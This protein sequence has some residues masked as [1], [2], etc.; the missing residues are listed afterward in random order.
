MI[1]NDFVAVLARALR[2]RTIVVLVSV[3]T[4]LPLVGCQILGP[5]AL[6]TGRGAY[7]DVIART[8]S[9]QTLGLIVRLRYSDPF[10]LL[11]VSGVTAGLR[12]STQAK[13]EAGFG[14]PGS[15]AGA[16]V[17]FSAGVSYEDNPLISYTPV[18]A[19]GFLREWLAPVTLETLALAMQGAARQD[20]LML[21]LA[22]VEGMNGLHSG[23]GAAVEE[24]TAFHRAV[25]LLAQFRDLGMALWVQESGATGRY[26]LILSRYSPGRIAE[27]EEFLRLLDLHGNPA[28]QSTIRIPVALG[29]RDADFEGLAVQTRSVAEIMHNV[30]ASIEV[31]GEHVKEGLV[32]ARSEPTG[33]QRPTLRIL[34]SS[35]APRQANVAVQHRGWWYYVD[36]TDLVSK[37]AFLMI[38]TLFLTRLTE[39]TRGAQGAP[40]LTIPVK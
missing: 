19:Q 6:S 13:G 31:P 8:S 40:L 33:V 21:L 39:A 26:E 18:D 34:S 10:G 22:L 30:A 14:S 24:R 4:L 29:V 1:V 32:E 3:S 7:N 36:D 2:L 15:Y 23:A 27:V 12:F 5:A 37:R 17:P 28:Q 25:T 9:E 20:T 16:L 11:A 38:Q 35:N